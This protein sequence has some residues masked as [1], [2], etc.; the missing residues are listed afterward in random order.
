M[1]AD[2]LR[3]Q[4]QANPQ[5]A[6]L[7]FQGR[8]WSYAEL[9]REVEAWC[10]R[11]AGLGLEPGARAAVL[12]PNCPDFVFLV[13]AAARLG[14]ALAPLNRRLAQAELE[15]QAERLRP[16]VLVGEGE[17]IQPFAGQGLR[18]LE[19][20]AARR[21]PQKAF[22]TPPFDPG[23]LQGLLFT[24]GTTGE[25]K[26]ARLSFANH[27][28]NALGSAAR[29][30]ML[31][32]DRWLSCLPLYH[33]GGLAVLFRS[34]LFGSCV[35]LHTGFDLQAVA[36]SKA[37]TL[38]S[39]VPTMLH[40]LLEA[41]VRFPPGLRLVL[42]GGAAATPELVG[43]AAERG[44]PVVASYGLTEAASQ[45]ATQSLAD[46]AHKPGC[47]GR[48]LLHVGLRILGPEG[49]AL[50]PGEVG[51]IALSGPTIT[52]GYE[53][54]PQATGRA[55][56]EGWLHTGD[57]G[58][59]D[60]D[61]ELWVLQRRSD[62]IVSGGENIY[63]AEVEQALRRHPAVAEVCVVGVPDREW[64]QLPAAAVVPRPG[65]AVDSEDLL[66]FARQSL[67]G[68]KLPRFI[69]RLERLPQTASGKIE[70]RQVQALVEEAY[71]RVAHS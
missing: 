54:D 28:W 2:W 6:A 1:S 35:E 24:S 53:D 17:R 8:A 47:S 4:A 42:L 44:L 21:L 68:Y 13:H 38:I 20:E 15:R 45:A 62:L 71:A 46:A 43:A 55:L 5:G 37:Y 41:G 34:C 48:P 63:P 33:V 58:Y 39:L 31:P 70:R 23:R 32:T 7:T 27:F 16:A 9:D 10:G 61:G 66:A 65:R 12:L 3:A 22:R 26:A 67:G 69:L 50:P 14:L 59:L 30:G 11:L 40:R 25:P 56:R 57:L 60:E 29:L 64:G 36:E 18:A 19:L 51:E 52:D 49:Q